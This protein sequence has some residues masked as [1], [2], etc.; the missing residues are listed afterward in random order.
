MKKEDFEIKEYQEIEVP[1]ESDDDNWFSWPNVLCTIPAGCMYSLGDYGTF[2]KAEKTFSVNLM[3]GY[4]Y[5]RVY[6][7]DSGKYI[8]YHVVGRES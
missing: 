8:V 4:D 6:Y 2:E 1:W 3:S 5:A 7:P